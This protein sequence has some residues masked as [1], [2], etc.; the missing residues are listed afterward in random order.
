M[1]AITPSQYPPV[2]FETTS[3]PA[4]DLVH[5]AGQ[6]FATDNILALAQSWVQSINRAFA[7]GAVTEIAT[8]FLPTG[9][10]RDFLTLEWN[11]HTFQGRDKIAD[12]LAS[13]LA[14]SRVC[15]FAVDLSDKAIKPVVLTPT[16]GVEWIQ[17]FLTFDNFVG[18]G[19]GV[20]RLVRDPLDS[21]SI[22]AF[23]LY[24]GL[25]SIN[26]HDELIEANRPLGVNH[27]QHQGRQS[28]AE[29]RAVELEFNHAEP[30]VIIVGAG[31]AGL[32]IAARLKMIGI[33]SL[34]LER[35]VRIGDNWRKRYKFLVLH[36]P[37]YYDH[38][39]Y[40][41]FPDSWPIFTPKDKLADFFESYASILELNVWTESSLDSASYDDETDKWT[42]EITRK[43][44]SKR[45]LHP[46]HIVQSTGHSGEPNIP[47]FPDQDKFKG[48]IVHSSQHTTGADF[49]GQKAI[50]VGCCNSGHDIAHDF[51][52]QGA[53]VTIYQRSSTYVMS[54]EN[55][56][57]QLFKGLYDPNGPGVDKADLVF[58]ST[59][60]NVNHL[61]HRDLTKTIAGLDANILNGLE[62]VGFKLDYGYDGSGFL[63]KYYRRGGGY[64]LDVGC[65]TL[66]AD[67]RV[68]V[69]QGA[70]IT[71]FTNDGVLFADGSE[72]KADII[73]LATG[74]KNMRETARKIFGDKVAD[75]CNEVWGLDDESELKT[76]WRDS[77]HP[78]FW[79]HGGNLS[80]CRFFSKRLA[81]QILAEELG[82]KKKS[83][84]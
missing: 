69:K 7:R 8:H 55:G 10:W 76:M 66:I 14:S 34:I 40:I 28:W 78:G 17:V 62:K 48:K 27:G 16:E 29:K 25:E 59:P 46:N 9:Y 19:Q 82:L 33:S 57:G 1:A 21:S 72:V 35:N 22:K 45:T 68:K 83:S 42:V 50:V 38:L 24:T 41:N 61:L 26:G 37:V 56:L 64:Y 49:K 74:Y 43:D 79:F 15:N 47:T 65:S 20:V 36:D 51:Y 23:T 80:H 5:K 60:V 11:F 39:P 6:S 3:T 2:S 75:R 52:E 63:M 84:K 18:K 31:Q 70:A 4:A 81:L 77:G 13:H 58:Y 73:V 12:F 67:G 30:T 71:S 32:T 44:G 54:S 53:D